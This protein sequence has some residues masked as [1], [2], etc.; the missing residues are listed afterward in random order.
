VG[1][2][3][4]APTDGAVSLPRFLVAPEELKAARVVLAGAQLHHLRARR[5]RVGSALVLAD[6]M[7][8]QRRGVVAALDRHQ[9]VI[10]I[11]DELSVH[12]DSTLQLTIAQAALKGDKLDWVIEKTT[13]LGVT[14]LVIF[15]SERTVGRVG[16]ERRTR[17]SRVASSAAQQCQRSTL[18]AIGG[19]ISFDELL[20]RST[21][22]VRLFFWEGHAG[23]GLA[24]VHRQHSRA[25]SVLAVIG[26]EGGF[27]T[28]EARRAEAAG[29]HTVSLGP[30]ILRAET[31]ALVAGTLCQFLWGDLGEDG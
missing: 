4:S 21:D 19:P 28:G 15:T 6:G 25:A 20:A 14:E 10:E 5:L 2:V 12:R 1:D 22:A 27:S 11:V 16:V 7:G 8:T 23:S 18:P 26:P 3:G 29:L 24:A 17:W 30:R 9:A 13:E 31:A